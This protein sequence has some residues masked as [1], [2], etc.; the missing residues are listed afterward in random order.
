MSRF[1]SNI[2]DSKLRPF[3]RCISDVSCRHFDKSFF[4]LPLIVYA[5][6]PEGGYVIAT[7]NGYILVPKLYDLDDPIKHRDGNRDLAKTYSIS[8]TAM[9]PVAQLVYKSMSKRVRPQKVKLI[10]S[11]KLMIV[12]NAISRLQANLDLILSL[13]LSTRPRRS[14]VPSRRISSSLTIEDEV[15]DGIR[16]E[17]KPMLSPDM[18]EASQLLVSF[19]NSHY[20]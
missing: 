7:R 19:H 8:Q 5:E 9:D 11:M 14:L 12:G 17:D 15:K 20:N 13:F 4:P 3:P 16:D 6:I 1:I 10:C 18:I 2:K